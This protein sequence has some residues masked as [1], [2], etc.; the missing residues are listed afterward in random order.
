MKDSNKI[1]VLEILQ[2]PALHVELNQSEQGLICMEFVKS[3]QFAHSKPPVLWMTS[4]SD[5]LL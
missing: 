1:K 3:A 4:L 2:V 5:G